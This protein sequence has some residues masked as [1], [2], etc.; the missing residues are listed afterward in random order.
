MS[1]VFFLLSSFFLIVILLFFYSI[2]FVGEV[3][4]PFMSYTSACRDLV[5]ERLGVFF[6]AA[7]SFGSSCISRAGNGIQ[8][9][10]VYGWMVGWLSV[11]LYVDEMRD[12]AFADC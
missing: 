1:R 10:G 5:M 9:L 12:S 3:G 2:N 4:L 8:P 11:W 7:G 6:F